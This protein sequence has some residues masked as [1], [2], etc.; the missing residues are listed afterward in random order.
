MR[1]SLLDPTLGV[2]WRYRMAEKAPSMS[3][4]VTVKW[5]QN[6]E[7]ESYLTVRMIRRILVVGDNLLGMMR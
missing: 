2:P 4:S 5:G 7:V 1:C 6:F 3:Q